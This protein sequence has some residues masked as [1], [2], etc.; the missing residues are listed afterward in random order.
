MALRRSYTD[1]PSESQKL[2]GSNLPPSLR[3]GAATKHIAVQRDETAP[4]SG[5]QSHP[6]ADRISLTQVPKKR[7]KR[8]TVG[9]ES[10]KG[11]GIQERI[12]RPYAIK[13]A[14]EDKP[15]HLLLEDSPDHH[16]YVKAEVLPGRRRDEEK[17]SQQVL[18]WLK[19]EVPQFRKRERSIEWV[20]TERS[21]TRK[22]HA[23]V[24]DVGDDF[25]SEKQAPAMA[26]AERIDPSPSESEYELQAMRTER[27]N[28]GRRARSS[29]AG[30]EHRDPQKTKLPVDYISLETLKYY[31][32]LWEHT[33]V[34]LYPDNARKAMISRH[35]SLQFSFR[36]TPAIILFLEWIATR[37]KF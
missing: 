22:H 33:K 32:V 31:G 3:W 15:R 12:R 25:G 1:G 17:G 27:R 10:N 28:A 4:Q 9:P 34:S 19:N 8:H 30:K 2:Y 11:L 20:N 18:E 37:L 16:R 21:D 36:M 26:G 13:A 35:L 5:L 7:D 6:K 23:T 14:H 24:D 29:S